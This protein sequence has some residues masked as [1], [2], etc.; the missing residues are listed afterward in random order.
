M[1]SFSANPGCAAPVA[2]NVGAILAQPGGHPNAR[3]TPT[4]Q[5]GQR[6]V[7]ERSGRRSRVRPGPAANAG[8]PG[9]ESSL[10]GAFDAP[11]PQGA[12][13]DRRLPRVLFQRPL[14]RP[15]GQTGGAGRGGHS[16]AAG[17]RAPSRARHAEGTAAQWAASRPGVRRC[18]TTPA[19][20]RGR[21]EG[22]RDPVP[23]P[24][25]GR[26]GPGP[27]GRGS[28]GRQSRP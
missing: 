13:R 2:G 12:R 21:R 9:E 15:G 28:S 20:S 4:I 16:M 11:P 3:L 14:R 26:P 17:S 8:I 7:P 22:S 1:A 19:G 25:R 5:S 10:S 6:G 24:G 18:L 27:R 23:E